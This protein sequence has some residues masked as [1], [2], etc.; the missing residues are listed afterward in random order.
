MK[1]TII[2]GSPRGLKANSNVIINWFSE[3]FSVNSIEK[4]EIF[5]LKEHKKHDIM[6]SSIKYCD[7]ILVVFPLYTDAMP[8]IVKQFIDSLKG[9]NELTEGKSFIFLVH[10]GFPEACHSRGIERYL[11]R[12]TLKLSGN[13]IGT[14]IKGGSEGL[15]VIPPWMTGKTRKVIFKIAEQFSSESILNKDLLKKLSKPEH[16]SPF[17]LGIYKIMSFLGLSNL[18]WNSML[19][20]NKAYKLRND[21]PYSKF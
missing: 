21:T 1:L 20:Q 7:A 4:N 11:K 6:Y 9:Q 17:R 3:G 5:H 12:L 10:S 8:G 2:N 13:Y 16:L 15:R 18:Y 14:I 19:K